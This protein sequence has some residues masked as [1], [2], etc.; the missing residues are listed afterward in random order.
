MRTLLSLRA[1]VLAPLLGVVTGVILL[2][3][4][5]VPLLSM[6]VWR[7]FA[8]EP[9]K[10]PTEIWSTAGEPDEPFARV[11]GPEWRPGAPVELSELPEH[12]PAAFLAAEDVRFRSHIGIDLIGVVRAMLT[13]VRAGEIM[14]G[15]STI[16]QQVV[17][18][19]YLTAE[20]TWRRKAEEAL[21]ALALELKLTK[22][23]ILEAYLNDVYL[24][25]LEG[26]AILGVDEAAQVYFGRDAT[27]LSVAEAALLAAIVR[28]PNR[29]TPEKRRELAE[30]RRNAVLRV[31][32][33]R[34]WISAD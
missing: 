12:V 32:H 30:R 21:W 13:N 10:V 6:I 20:R 24:G 7:D 19:R 8:G 18:A 26:R 1:L 33:E 3:T 29:D 9:W 17:K 15:G 11:Y 2:V 27:K 23:Q 34:E 16:S 25:H 28:A 31:M 5:V 4:G 22:E 14:Q